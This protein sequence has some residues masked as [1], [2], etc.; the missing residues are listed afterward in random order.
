MKVV[1]GEVGW[2]GNIFLKLLIDLLF[3]RFIL[4]IVL[5]FIRLLKFILY[6]LWGIF[7]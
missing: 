5:F 4:K 1:G 6:V 7:S 2:I 3:L